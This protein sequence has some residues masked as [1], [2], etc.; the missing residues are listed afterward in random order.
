MAIKT[1]RCHLHCEWQAR[2]KRSRVAVWEEGDPKLVA[3]L[4]YRS[5]QWL[6]TGL[7]TLTTWVFY[8]TP[9]PS[10]PGAALT[11][12][13]HFSPEGKKIKIADEL[14]ERFLRTAI[15]GFD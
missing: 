9:S 15:P 7:L 3:A 11:I 8:A 12:L 5:N 10:R 4:I 6:S 13:S 14:P 1:E 2:D